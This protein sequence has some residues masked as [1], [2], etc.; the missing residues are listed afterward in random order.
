MKFPR[1]IEWM[2]EKVNDNTGMIRI[3]GFGGILLYAITRGIVIALGMLII[4]PL[5]W[6]KEKTI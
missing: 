6:L 4:L 3:L 1:D 5:L 2:V